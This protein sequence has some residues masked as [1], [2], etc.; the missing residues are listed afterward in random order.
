D[1]NGNFEALVP[2]SRYGQRTK[3]PRRVVFTLDR[4][5]SMQGVPL[6]QARKALEACL[7]VL[8]D[9]DQFNIIAFDNQVKTF[10]PKMVEATRS[11]VDQARGLLEA[12][13]A[14]GGTDLPIVV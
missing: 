11:S 4:S 13:E 12:I 6:A 9:K 2:S 3:A 1:G 5:G 14:G 10:R 7:G 8:S